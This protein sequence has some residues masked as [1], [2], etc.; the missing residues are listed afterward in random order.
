MA[1][2]HRWESSSSALCLPLVMLQLPTL[3]THSV[4]PLYVSCAPLLLQLASLAVEEG[5]KLAQPTTLLLRRV[6]APFA[7]SQALLHELYRPPEMHPGNLYAAA[8]AAAGP[9]AVGRSASASASR[10]CVH[11][12]A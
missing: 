9:R 10:C 6:L 12:G 1:R 7:R 11:G 5:L 4:H 2:S 8:A 3:P